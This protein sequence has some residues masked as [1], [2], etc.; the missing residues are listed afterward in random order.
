M[1]S[2]ENQ[3]Q[4]SLSSHS[5]WKSLR[6][7]HIPSTPTT[8]AVEKWKSERQDSHF[9]TASIPFL[10]TKEISERSILRA[11]ASPSP[12]AHRWIGIC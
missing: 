8:T 5:P 7:S 2:E 1:E 12:R 11:R 3:T 10:L 4:V 9:P 6:D